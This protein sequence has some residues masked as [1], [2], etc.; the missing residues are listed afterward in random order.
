M[1]DTLLLIVGLVAFGLMAVGILFTI[2]EFRSLPRWQKPE[3]KS[4]AAQAQPAPRP[5]DKGT[6]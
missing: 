5:K 4:V 3:F 6:R 1:N 2:L